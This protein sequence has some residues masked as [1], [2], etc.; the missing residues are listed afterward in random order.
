[1]NCDFLRNL[2]EYPNL[3]LADERKGTSKDD[4]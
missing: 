1:M 2:S 4:G 3:I